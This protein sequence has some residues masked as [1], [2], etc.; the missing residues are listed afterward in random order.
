V[1]GTSVPGI[2]N[3]FSNVGMTDE[4]IIGVGVSVV[5]NSV[6]GIV[7]IG[8]TGSVGNGIGIITIPVGDNGGAYVTQVGILVARLVDERVACL[9]LLGTRV[10]DPN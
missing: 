4:I 1:V 8:I 3:G 7:G 5:G 2:G 10:G 9:L 6:A